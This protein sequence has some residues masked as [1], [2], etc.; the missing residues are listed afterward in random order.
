MGKF[1]A[2]AKALGLAVEKYGDDAA[3]ILE[4]VDTPEMATGLKGM[5][6]EAYLKALD[7]VYGSQAKRAADMGFGP[8]NWYH[9]AKDNFE[10]FDLEKAREALGENIWGEGVY[11]SDNPKIASS[12]TSSGIGKSGPVFKLKSRGGKEATNLN[13]LDAGEYVPDEKNAIFYNGK[14]DA[15]NMVERDPSRLRSEFAAFDPR[16]KD[17]SLLMAGALAAP[18]A[19]QNIDMNPLNDIKAGFDVY[20]EGKEK[21]A[22]A[23]ASQLNI[24][25]NPNDESYI[26]EGLKVGADPINFIPGA[27]GVGLGL[28]Q[29]GSQMMPDTQGSALKN[30]LNKAQGYQ[31]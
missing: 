20:D 15:T 31:P 12:Y 3:R 30:R 5:E 13:L 10:K 21:L 2:L 28:I 6:R 1:D 4:K 8:K 24:G 19:E 18:I 27:G 29:A 22:R 25:K 11:L 23:L 16:F 14:L 17:S 9:G 7:D 26:T